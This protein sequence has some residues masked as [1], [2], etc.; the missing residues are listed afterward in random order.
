[1][2]SASPAA[3]ADVRAVAQTLTHSLTT[4]GGHYLVGWVVQAAHDSPALLAELKR[5]IA[6]HRRADVSRP[7]SSQCFITT[8]V[9]I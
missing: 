5:F 2:P 4:M 9:D 3:A 1:M 6:S 7:S 8:P